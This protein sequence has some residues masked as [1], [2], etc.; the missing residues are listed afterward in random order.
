M[1]NI[2]FDAGILSVFNSNPSSDPVQDSKQNFML[3]FHELLKIKQKAEADFNA[4]PEENQIY[5]FQASKYDLTLP[6]KVTVF[7]RHKKIPNILK[8]KTRW[9]AFA[10]SKGIQKKRR[11]R[12]VYDETKEDWVPRWGARSIKK[13]KE[14]ENW[15]I[16]LKPEQGNDADPFR[17]KGL[18]KELKKEQ[19]KLKQMKNVEKKNM[20]LGLIFTNFYF[21]QLFF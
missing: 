21:S 14:K 20:S 2:S 7:P 5:D 4:Q 16:E 8:T 9:E 19:E 15:A 6:E 3:L 17:E 12:M 18:N 13:N 10:A 1:S 11:S